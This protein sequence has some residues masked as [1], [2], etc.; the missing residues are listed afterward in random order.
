MALAVEARLPREITV[1][2]PTRT[3]PARTRAPAAPTWVDRI[4]LDV[5]ITVGRCAIHRDDL[6]RLAVRSLVTLE[7]PATG[8]MATLEILGGTVG[9][10]TRPG[11]LV[12]EVTTG[13][14]RR[15]MALPDEAHAELSVALGTTQLTLRQ[16]TELTVG[17]I[18]QLGRPLGGP[19][20]LRVAGRVLGRGELVDV[21][22]ELAVRI[23]SLGD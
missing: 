9:L 13:Y 6:R 18:V 5:P 8:A 20:E 1:R 16:I 10:T 7:R 15:D 23:V 19:F 12:A 4:H 17:Q 14:V 21:D 3:V 11:A 2:A 22:G